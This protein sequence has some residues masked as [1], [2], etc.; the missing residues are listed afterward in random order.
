MPEPSKPPAYRQM[1]DAD[2]AVTAYVRKNALEALAASENRTMDWRPGLAGHFAHLIRHDPQGS[3]VAEIDGLVVGYAQS[4]V[5][6]DIW[7]LS[8]LF[9][10]PEVHGSGIGHELLRRT[11]QYGR[12]RGATIFSVVSSRSPSAQPL[13]MRAGMFAIAAGYRMTG[14]V[15]PL[16]KLPHPN[17]AR[18]RMVDCEGWQDRLSEMDIEVFG[19]DRRVDHEYYLATLEDGE[20]LA[21]VRDGRFAGYAYVGREGIG[22]LAA[23][24][25][26]DQ[27]QLL[28]ICADWLTEH[29]VE[30]IG[31]FGITT[32]PTVM[33][34]LLDAGWRAEHVTFFK[35]SAP[36][37]KFDR[38]QPY[39]GLLL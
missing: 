32:N 36:F 15:A 7:F 38:Y 10:Q 1:T 34:A 22:P 3:W 37:G 17:G 35:S 33:S 26:A 24:E 20:A 14:P 28:R 39:G 23:H 27:L 2:I 11:Q 16:L 5:R 9:V 8:Q 12:D 31:M 29:S 19:A 13:Y 30:S 4:F 6:G 21:L 25:P 18:K